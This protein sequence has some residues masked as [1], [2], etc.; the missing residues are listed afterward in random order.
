MNHSADPGGNFA[1]DVHRRTLG[2]LPLP[3]DDPLD[4][5]ALVERM[6]PDEPTELDADEA[7]EV[8]QDLEADGHATQLKDGWKQT[9]AGLDTL[10]APIATEADDG[11]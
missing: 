3:T 2:H 11:E 8:L 5:E 4:V 7:T 6:A 1:S 10:N 9:K